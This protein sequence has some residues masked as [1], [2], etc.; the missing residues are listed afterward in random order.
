[1]INSFHEDSFLEVNQLFLRLLKL[2]GETYGVK[3]VFCAEELC[4]L[5]GNLREPPFQGM[6]IEFFFHVAALS[7]RVVLA[8]VQFQPAPLFS[9]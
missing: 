8:Y 7:V 3:N 2:T 5:R 6:S 1:M 4:I 9:H